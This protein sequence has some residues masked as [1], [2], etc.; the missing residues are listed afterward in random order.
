MAWSRFHPGQPSPARLRQEGNPAEVVNWLR[1]AWE[2]LDKTP[3]SEISD[4]NGSE[5]F[6]KH[7]A[8]SG[9]AIVKPLTEALKALGRLGEARRI[10]EDY[11]RM[12]IR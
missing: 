9:E 7:R 8:A 2:A 10:E 6:K 11:Q 12:I 3:G 5:D 1:E 4:K